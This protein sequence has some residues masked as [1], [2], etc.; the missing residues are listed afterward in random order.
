M[1]R[2]FIQTFRFF[3]DCFINFNFQVS[4]LS[5][6][7]SIF[8]YSLPAGTLFSSHVGV[9]GNEKTALHAIF[10]KQMC[11]QFKDTTDPFLTLILYPELRPV[12]D[13]N[14]LTLNTSCFF[15]IRNVQTCKTLFPKLLMFTQVYNLVWRNKRI[16]ETHCFFSKKQNYSS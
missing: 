4:N 3:K 13:C 11:T 15:C 2:Q 6:P 1:M 16:P 7:L 5:T 8:L 10:T 12:K 9:W 14:V